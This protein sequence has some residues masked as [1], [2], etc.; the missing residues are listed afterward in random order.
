MGASSA[1]NATR[2]SSF[3]AA[4]RKLANNAKEPGDYMHPKI[5]LKTKKI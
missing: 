5:K 4:L 1:L 3:A 2:T